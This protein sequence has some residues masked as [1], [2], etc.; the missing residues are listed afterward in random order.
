MPEERQKI[1]MWIFLG[2]VLGGSAYWVMD[3]MDGP[4]SVDVDCLIDTMMYLDLD[5]L[6]TQYAKGSI[7]EDWTIKQVR[8]LYNLKDDGVRP[9]IKGF[10]NVIL[11]R[12]ER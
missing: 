8:N 2:L 1:A 4:E 11:H 5:N 7:N 6:S 10:L 12:C 3:Y 9:L